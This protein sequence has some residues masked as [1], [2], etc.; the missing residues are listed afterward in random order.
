MPD[1]EKE[2][3]KRHKMIAESSRYLTLGT[4]TFLPVLIGALVGYY[5]IDERYG[6]S[7]TWTIIMTLLGFVAG[8]YSLFKTVMAVNKKK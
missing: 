2:Q 6:T 5:L 7:P 4:E 3:E 8:M 1:K